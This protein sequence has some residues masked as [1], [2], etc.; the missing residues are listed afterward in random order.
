MI[1]LFC[2]VWFRFRFLRRYLDLWPS[3]IG[4]AYRLLEMVGE[5]SPGH[6][7]IHLLSASGLVSTWFAPAQ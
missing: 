7:P 4:R 6:G 3:H 2:V 1:P 5:C